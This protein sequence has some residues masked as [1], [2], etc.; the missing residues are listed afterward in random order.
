MCEGEGGFASEVG[1]LR[2]QVGI[3]FEV[4]RRRAGLV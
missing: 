2:S 1:R 3:G 4:R